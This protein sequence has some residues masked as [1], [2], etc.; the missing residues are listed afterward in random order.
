MSMTTA[1]RAKAIGKGRFVVVVKV[2][3]AMPQL[4]HD[5]HE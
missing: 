3:I 2:C 1:A 4:D 5:L